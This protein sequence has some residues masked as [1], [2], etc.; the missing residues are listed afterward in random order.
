MGQISRLRAAAL[1]VLAAFSF[2]AFVAA[3]PPATAASTGTL[4]DG[5]IADAMS[6]LNAPYRWG[7]DGP[8]TFDCSG[9]VYRVYADNGIASR[10]G[11][12]RS[13]YAQLTY[14][15]SRG[16]TSTSGGQPG[17]LV[18]FNNGSHVGIYLGNGR[19]I[20][21]L[22]QGVRVTSIYGLTV[23]F[24]TFGH[25]HLGLA[26]ATYAATSI[27]IL[28]YRYA[29]ARLNVRTGPS[30]AYARITTV[31]RGSRLGV[32]DAHRDAYGR[33]WYRVRSTSG[34]IGW[35]AGWYTRR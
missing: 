24:M 23:P 20:S 3:T 30:P 10:I 19:V 21:A 5:V 34:A 18:F 33:V 15:R 27:R 8:T 7:T 11:S 6:H 2:F 22:T 31:S 9:L 17:D 14:L 13:A 25:T 1:A 32:L 4:A 16:Q 29:T 35:V 26:T 12:T 28:Y